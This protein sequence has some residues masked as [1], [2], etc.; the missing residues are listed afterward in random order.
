M[1][2]PVVMMSTC[3]QILKRRTAPK[4]PIKSVR[5]RRSRFYSGQRRRRTDGRGFYFFVEPCRR[6]GNFAG[7]VAGN[8]RDDG[9]VGVDE[10]AGF[11]REG[12]FRRLP[13]DGI[14]GKHG[15]R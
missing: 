2:P 12:F 13:A 6:R 1:T 11:E 5:R 15:G 9:G 3:R 14:S 4:R 10:A 7:D 8:R